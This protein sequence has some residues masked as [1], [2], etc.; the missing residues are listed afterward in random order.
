MDQDFQ[1][2]AV[3]HSSVAV[4]DGVELDLA[5]EHLAGVHAAVEDTGQEGVDVGAGGCGSAGEGDVRAEEAAETDGGI[6]VLGTPTRL[7]TPPG[8]TAPIACS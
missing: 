3:V 2:F 7:I 1:G 4:G 5:V 6:F 8:R